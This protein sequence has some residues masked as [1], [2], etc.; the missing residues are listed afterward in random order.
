MT[1][2]PLCGPSKKLFLGVEQL[3]KSTESYKKVKFK[4]DK[5]SCQYYDD[6]YS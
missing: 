1:L 6:N 3:C 5:K 4:F 2:F